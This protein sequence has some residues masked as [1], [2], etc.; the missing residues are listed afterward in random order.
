MSLLEDVSQFRLRIASQLRGRPTQLHQ[1][2][3]PRPEDL[4][5]H[6]PLPKHSRKPEP[7]SGRPRQ[8]R[9]HGCDTVVPR[10]CVSC[11]YESHCSS[12]RCNP[13]RRRH[14]ASTTHCSSVP[15]FPSVLTFFLR[16]APIRSAILGPRGRLVHH[17]DLVLRCVGR[18]RAQNSSIILAVPVIA[19]CIVPVC[20]WKREPD[21]HH[22]HSS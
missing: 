9:S 19:H 16:I 4:D 20:G 10:S 17:S 21:D 1:V 22:R 12:L 7:R 14:P 5:S 15:N 13:Q 6:P 11:L 2:P 8:Y 3:F 18:D